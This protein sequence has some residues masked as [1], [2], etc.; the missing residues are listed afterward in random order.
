MAR[1]D[2]VELSHAVAAGGLQAAH[3]GG[4]QTA[5]AHE[6]INAAVNA[7]G[8]GLWRGEVSIVLD[9]FDWEKKRREETYSPDIDDQA[10]NWLTGV[11]VDELHFEMDGHTGLAFN[12]VLT[13]E[14]AEDVLWP[15]CYL[16]SPDAARVGREQDRGV[17]A[18]VVDRLKL[19]QCSKTVAADVGFYGGVRLQS[20][21]VGGIGRNSHGLER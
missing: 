17:G 1:E 6:G 16:R 5:L 20:F 21:K 13:D 14:L 10:R 12:D 11:D 9:G 15:D 3:I 4:V 2:D 18:V 7:R 8:V 19:L